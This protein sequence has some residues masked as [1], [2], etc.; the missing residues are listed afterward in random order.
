MSNNLITVDSLDFDQIKNNIRTFLSGQS[1]FSDYNF[2]GSA[3]QTLIDI[4]AY[5]THYNALYVNMALNESFLDSASKYSSVVSLAKTIGYTAKSV[6]SAIAKLTVELSDVK[7]APATTLIMP[8]GTKFRGLI[9]NREYVFQ[10]YYA[11]TAVFDGIKYSFD[12]DVIEGTEITS[13]YI[14]TEGATF[15]IP[16]QQADMSSIKVEVQ[17]NGG[18]V[19]LTSFNSVSDLLNI[20]N[21]DNVYFVKQREDLFYE[22]YFGDDV[23]GK[24]LATGAIVYITYYASNGQSANGCN[25]FYYSGGF[26][27]DALYQVI[28]NER[29]IGGADR[30]SIQSIKFNA[31]RNYIS[32]NRAVTES[33]YINQIL[34]NFP[35]VESLSVWG[36]EKHEPPRYGSVYICAKPHDRL[37]LTLV[38]KN[39]IRD[40]ISSQRAVLQVDTRFVDPTYTHLVINSGVYYNPDKTTRSQND[41]NSITTQIIES[42]VNSLNS[43]QKNFRY[44]KLTNLIDT[45]DKAIVSNITSVSIRQY[46]TP[47]IGVSSRYRVNTNNP[48]DKTLA[49]IQSSKF[50]LAG[51]VNRFLIEN[52]DAGILYLI[53]ILPN[54]IK[55]RHLPVGNVDFST[56]VIDINAITISLLYDARFYLNIKLSSYDVKPLRDTILTINSSDITVSSYSDGDA[57]NSSRIFTSIR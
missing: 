47:N 53:E 25:N 50:F 26:R 30:E 35:Y 36:G 40:F 21:T 33:D 2:E 34:Q 37:A 41:I 42:Y 7:D 49:A 3:L 9:G 27:G 12:V 55:S 15:V 31:P 51:Y 14:N 48:I 38:E 46:I 52:D 1:T 8:A 6:K 43:L 56:G 24:K 5:N 11:K 18:T 23:I 10:T 19:S 45:A 17:E 54:G 22:I 32:Q 28:T 4:L 44:S 16:N 57:Y 39:E 13:T 20:N 29:A